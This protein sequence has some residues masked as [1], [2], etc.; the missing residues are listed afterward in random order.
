MGVVGTGVG[1][2]AF[3]ARWVTSPCATP[4]WATRSPTATA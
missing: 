1:P 2:L 4:S 3:A